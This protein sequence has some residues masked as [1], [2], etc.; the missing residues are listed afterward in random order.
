MVWRTDSAIQLGDGEAANIVGE[1]HPELIQ[2]LV[3]LQGHATLAEALDDA[4]RRGLGRRH[5]RRLLRAIAETGGLDDGS[6][7]TAAL[8]DIDAR[9]RDRLTGELAAARLAHRSAERGAR[10]LADRLR[11]R[12][13]IS[14]Q[15]SV[16]DAVAAALTAAGIGAVVPA[17]RMRSASRR[18]R[19]AAGAITCQVMCDAGADGAPT[20]PDALSLDVPHLPIHVHGASAR[21]GPLVVPGRTSCLRCR[22]LHRTDADSAWPRMAVQRERPCAPAINSALGQL[23]AAWGALQVI[24]L[25][26]N[27]PP[28]HGSPAMEWEVSLPAAIIRERPSPAHPLCGCRWWAA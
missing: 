25:V 2:W 10:A 20:T 5:P 18:G 23:A 21:I 13:A 26:E 22:D 28:A 11:A 19:R 12:I 3:T 8:R 1:V 24:A 17:E 15:G 16:A 14:G 4:E 9:A 27:G 6:V 7:T